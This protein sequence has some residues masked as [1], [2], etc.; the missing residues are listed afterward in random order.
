MIEKNNE[1]YTKASTWY[2]KM[3]SMNCINDIQPCQKLLKQV[4]T[5][6]S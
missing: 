1:K 3:K 4:I 6:A 2:L 5:K